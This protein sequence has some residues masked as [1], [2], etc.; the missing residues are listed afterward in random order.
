MAARPRDGGPW[1]AA[2][3]DAFRTEMA[4]GYALAEPA[5]VLGWPIARR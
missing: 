3:D 5:L 2:V 1:E 4:A